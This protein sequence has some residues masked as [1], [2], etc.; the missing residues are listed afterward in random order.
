M[1]H[2]NSNGNKLMAV[3]I[4]KH[5]MEIIHLLTDQNPIEV[6]VD[7]IFNSGPREDATFIGSAGVARCQAVISLLRGVL[8][9]QYI[10][11][12]L[13]MVHERVLSRMSRP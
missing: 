9:K 5:V 1:M 11:L 2:R 13:G 6:I 3:H 4:V 7:A 12:Q 10:F 8:T